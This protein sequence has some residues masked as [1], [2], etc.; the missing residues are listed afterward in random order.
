VTTELAAAGIQAWDG[1]YYA[2]EP[3]R[4]LGLA[5]RG[6]V[7]IG[8]LHYNTEAE[9]DRALEALESVARVA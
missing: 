9:V 4:A 1:D 5:D 3:M 2:P 8:F 6:A 7:R